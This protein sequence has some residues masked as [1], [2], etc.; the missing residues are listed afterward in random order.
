MTGVT[1]MSNMADVQCRGQLGKQVI[2]QLSVEYV[3]DLAAFQAK[4][5]IDMFGTAT[6]M[7]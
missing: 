7:Q 6:G 4:E 3:R 5:L 2:D 1:S